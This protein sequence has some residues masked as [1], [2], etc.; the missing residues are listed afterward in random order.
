MRVEVQV[1][2]AING[3]ELL[4]ERRIDT[5]AERVLNEPDHKKEPHEIN[6]SGPREAPRS[7]F[8]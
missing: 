6:T 8:Y 7:L 1:S 2:P 5:I 3:G 4:I